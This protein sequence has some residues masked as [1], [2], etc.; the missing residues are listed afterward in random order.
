MIDIINGVLQP[1][2]YTDVLLNDIKSL[3]NKMQC[4]RYSFIS[5]EA[6]QLRSTLHQTSLVSN[7]TQHMLFLL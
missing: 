3:I 4:V 1:E 5:R 2:I 7:I 6:N